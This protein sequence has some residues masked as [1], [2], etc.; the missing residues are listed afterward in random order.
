M[1]Q[2][3]AASTGT[4]S[5]DTLIQSVKAKCQVFFDIKQKHLALPV[6]KQKEIEEQ[7]TKLYKD[8]DDDKDEDVDYGNLS[9]PPNTKCKLCGKAPQSDKSFWDMSR[10]TR[11]NISYTGLKPEISMWCIGWTDVNRGLSTSNLL[12]Q[13]VS[14]GPLCWNNG[15]KPTC[16]ERVCDAIREWNIP[17][18]VVVANDEKKEE[19]IVI[20]QQQQNKK[21]KKSCYGPIRHHL[22]KGGGYNQWSAMTMCP[23]KSLKGMYRHKPWG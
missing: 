10:D 13:S 4:N 19:I 2:P 12:G 23:T 22:H 9:I 1:S 17:P 5:L 7:H 21:K 11:A 20:T 14:I 15:G 3:A 6:D 8:D 16:Y 18:L